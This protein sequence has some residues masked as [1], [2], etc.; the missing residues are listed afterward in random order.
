MLRRL[1]LVSCVASCLPVAE[2]QGPAKEVLKVEKQLTDRDAKVRARAAWDLGQMG[3][4]DS[5]PALTQALEDPSSA[6]RANAAASLWKLGAA[7]KP[8]I[9]ALRGRLEDRSGVVVGN[10]AG[11]LRKLGVPM[12]ELVPAY[13]RLLAMPDCKSVVI[14][15]KALANEVPPNELFDA[16][17]ECA[18]APGADFD[19]RRDA[20]EAL[21]KIVDRR[22]R[23]MVP[24][25]LATLERLGVRDGSVLI[26]A[27]ASLDPP[28]KEAVP[29]LVELLDSGNESTR[30]SA[31]SGLGRMGSTALPA[32]P[33]LVDILQSG[34]VPEARVG[35]AE[36]LGRIGPS[37][38]PAAVPALTRAARDDKWPKV[39]STALTALGEMGPAARE[40]IPVLR[41]ALKDPD[42]W[43]SLA[44]RNALFRVEP[45]KA[46]EVAAIS[47]QSR[48]VQKG[49]LYDDL[50]QLSTVLPSRVPE[51]YE[52]V[53]YEDFAMATAPCSDTKSGRCRFTYKAGA[54]TGPDDGSGDCDKKIQLSRVDFSVVPGLVRQ[55]PGLLGSPSGKV[56]VVQLSPGVFCKSHGWIVHVKDAGMVEFKLNG[57]VDKVRKF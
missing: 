44:A 4:T 54:V 34:T 21:R 27:I 46:Q 31:I 10:A 19:T 41:A 20:R 40:A 7:S 48:S 17:W 37:C 29:V 50:S 26:S 49:S 25:I 2:A 35:A 5:V 42:G 56:D 1:V 53:V 11:A 57:K 8:A 6:V 51:V 14:G 30:K 28:V 16:A 23:V 39:R 13:R 38:A 43:I 12:A 52:L 22:D 18:E 45:D 3:A 15:L 47:D 24:T 32:V 36:A 33:R 9:P 55:A